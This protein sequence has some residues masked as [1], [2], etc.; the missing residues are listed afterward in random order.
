[1][2][3]KILYFIGGYLTGFILG[4]VVLFLGLYLLHEFFGLL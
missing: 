4:P 2:A 3:K 1:M